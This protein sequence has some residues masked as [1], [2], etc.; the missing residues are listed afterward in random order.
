MQIS[1]FSVGNCHYTYDNNQYT[2]LYLFLY[3][4]SGDFYF[5]N[6]LAPSSR[7]KNSHKGKNESIFK[8]VNMESR[9]ITKTMRRQENIMKY[10]EKDFNTDLNTFTTSNGQLGTITLPKFRRSVIKFQQTLL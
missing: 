4:F 7:S 2:Y 1:V 8:D 10:K 5:S 3:L 6:K 9:P